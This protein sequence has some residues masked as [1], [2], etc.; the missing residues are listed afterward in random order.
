MSY[1]SDSDM[2]GMYSASYGGSDDDNDHSDSKSDGDDAKPAELVPD[3]VSVQS[4]E[5]SNQLAK[6]KAWLDSFIQEK[7]KK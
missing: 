1:G 7:L 6:D 4:D 5:N 2:S 3:H